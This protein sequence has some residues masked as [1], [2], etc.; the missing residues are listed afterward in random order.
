MA[1]LEGIRKLEAILAADVAGYSR[2]MQKVITG[3]P[4]QR[5]NLTSFLHPI[6]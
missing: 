6:N 3:T 2:L 1:D 5:K 4:K